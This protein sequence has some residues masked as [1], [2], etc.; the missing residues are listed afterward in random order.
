MTDNHVLPELSAYLD[1][2]SADGERIAQH[3]AQCPVCAQRYRQLA[4]LSR[5]VQSL[6]M[7][8]A[9]PGFATRVVA[10]VR[11]TDT[12]PAR[13]WR[14][15][16]GVP[17]AAAAIVLIAVV[18]GWPRAGR[19]TPSVN[20]AAV[21]PD[22]SVLL[23]AIEE[24]IAEAPE[25]VLWEMSVFEEE[26]GSDVLTEDEWADALADDVWFAGVADAYEQDADLGSVLTELDETETMVLKE[27][28]NEYV[29]RNWET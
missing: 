8:E 24:R 11:E 26:T 25:S 19:E 18:G 21:L 22:E 7:A 10:Q 9:R 28:L 23:A 4:E 15:R 29:E 2:E 12:H 14:W 13:L 16:I 3:L 17:A 5:R 20:T 6:P 27:L 1:G